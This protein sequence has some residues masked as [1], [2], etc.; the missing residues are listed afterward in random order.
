MDTA[1]SSPMTSQMRTMG[2]FVGIFLAL[3]AVVF[4]IVEL[5]FVRGGTDTAFQRLQSARGEA[6]D[7]VVLGASHALPLRFGDVPARLAGDTGQRMMVLAEVGAGPLYN[8]FLLEQAIRDLRIGRLL[9][10]VDAFTFSAATWN[11]GRIGERKLLA[12]TPLRLSTARILAGMV[13]TE[14]VDPRAL[15]DYLTGFSNLNPVERFPQEGWRGEADFDR[16]FRPSRHAVS[17][18]LAYLYPDGAPA[19]AMVERYLDTLDGILAL[20]EAHDIGVTVVKLPLP[21]AMRAGLPGEAAFD[22]ALGERLADRG[23]AFH[24]L[25]AAMDDPG[26]YFDTDHLNRRGVDRLYRD[27]LGA[28]LQGG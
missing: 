28:I 27:F 7:W 6:V 19:A 5:S 9:Y 12:Q 2:T 15:L 23:I 18:R 8:R 13:A 20:A 11:E 4:A 21:E 26:L 24:D 22:R 10:V 14:G 1:V 3:Y 25:S 17:A 16:T